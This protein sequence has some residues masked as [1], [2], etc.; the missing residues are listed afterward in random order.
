MMGIIRGDGW[1]V[2]MQPAGG[3]H[4]LI[5]LGKLRASPQGRRS[6]PLGTHFHDPSRRIPIHYGCINKI[7]IS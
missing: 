3:P 1:A 6:A 4:A 7:P 5:D 2:Q